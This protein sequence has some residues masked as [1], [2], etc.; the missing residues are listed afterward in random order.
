MKMKKIMS[1][2]LVASCLVFTGCGNQQQNNTSSV[3]EETQTKAEVIMYA[4]Y[5][6]I[7]DFGKMYD[8]EANAEKEQLMSSIVESGLLKVYDVPENQKSD[9]EEWETK[10]VENGFEL[11]DQTEA[12]GGFINTY[13]NN[14][15]SE[16]V[17]ASLAKST[18]EEG[19]YVF[20]LTVKE[21]AA[22][23]LPTADDPNI[24][25]LIEQQNRNQN[26]GL[27]L[28]QDNWIYGLTWN[29]DGTGFFAKIRTDGSDYTK[30]L[31]EPVCDLF[32]QNGYI[33]GVKDAG[34]KQGIYRVRTS[35]EEGTLIL[36][37]NEADMQYDSGYIYYSTDKYSNERNQDLC[38]L[39]RCNL[40]GTGVEEVLS[41]R[42]FCWYVFG[43]TV[44][45]QD[46]MDNES[47]HLYNMTTKSD[48]K[49]ND[50]TSYCPIY[51]G[52]YIYYSSPTQEDNGN[53]RIWKVKADGAENQQV[54]DYNIGDRIALYD[55]Y[56]YYQNIDDK[57]RLYRVDKSGNNM[58][59]ISQDTNCEYFYFSGDLLQYESYANGYEYI[60]KAV[61]CDVDG[62]NASKIELREWQ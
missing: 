26:D 15:T 34:D 7:P 1:L 36:E 19:G 42:V 47:L 61:L 28:I 40:D 53:C 24:G 12:D 50:Q 37:V 2:I 48:Q 32:I 58:I 30:L 46:D 51:D 62:G 33:Y 4:E 54:S 5:A 21:N 49:L 27:Y 16:I 6:D 13:Q 41:K 25:A 23:A 11:V 38:H 22:A 57:Y 39:Y 31:N 60:D 8:I 45:Y 18:A 52:D 35:G 9:V 29:D 43:D 10:L 44:L 17:V 56:I 20:I 14:T 59:Q 3:A 55:D